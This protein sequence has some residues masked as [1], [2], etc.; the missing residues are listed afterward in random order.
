MALTAMR[1]DMRAPDFGAPT[2]D[3]YRAAL[4][5]AEWADEAGLPA[6]DGAD[7]N[8]LPSPLT[9]AAA[10]AARTR[11]IQIFVTVLVLPLHDP[12]RVA[13]DSAVVQTLSGGRLNLTFGVGYRPHEFEM[14]GVPM[15]RRGTL[16]EEYVGILRRGWSG[17]EVEHRGAQFRVTPVPAPRPPLVLLGG[18]SEA[19]ARRAARI[20]D[21]FLPILPEPHVVAAYHDERERLGL[22]PGVVMGTAAAGFVYV[23]EDVEAA[24]DVIG[25]HALDD[26]RSYGRW[27]DGNP[28]AVAYAACETVEDVRASGLYR[29]LTPDECVAYAEGLGPFGTIQL[30]PLMGGLDP[31]FAWEGLR[32]FRERVLPRL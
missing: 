15:R 7:D 25:P 9:M 26:A 18:G 28:G 32:L 1:F 21:G 12:V 27:T 31:D 30:H 4:D 14:F 24:W 5:M 23:A 20:A 17:E 8:Y 16:L 22:G 11:R 29:V 19:A 6:V 13:E 2:A 10:I 3:L